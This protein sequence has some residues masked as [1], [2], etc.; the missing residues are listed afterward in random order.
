[1]LE[2]HEVPG[3]SDQSTAGAGRPRVA[4]I[5]LRKSKSLSGVELQTMTKVCWKCK[6]SQPATEFGRD[7]RYSDGLRSMCDGCN[8][9]T[10]REYRQAN[11]ERCREYNRAYYQANKAKCAEY[12]RKYRRKK[13]GR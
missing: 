1:V 13:A 8:R 9:Q 12:S 7:D 10:V 5:S 2:V 3:G 11:A 6:R 4:E